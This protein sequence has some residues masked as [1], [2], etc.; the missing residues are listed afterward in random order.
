[1]EPVLHE[2]LGPLGW[3]L[4]AAGVGVACSAAALSPLRDQKGARR[5]V[6]PVSEF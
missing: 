1:M 4:A 3:S 6:G 2:A 5:N